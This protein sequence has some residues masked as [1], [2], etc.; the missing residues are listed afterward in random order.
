MAKQFKK[1]DKV[2]LKD[3]LI[4]GKHY[5]KYKFLFLHCMKFNGF[6]EIE[7]IS[8]IRTAY[9]DSFYYPFTMLTNE[10]ETN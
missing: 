2:K 1:G 7:S 5:G 8:D 4:V 10:P 6:K 3:G 9:I